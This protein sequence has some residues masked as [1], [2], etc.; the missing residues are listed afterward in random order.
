[1]PEES[2]LSTG[3]QLADST[4]PANWGVDRLIDRQI[5]WQI[6]R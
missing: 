3:M 6:D 1:M 5:D 2:Y 4:V